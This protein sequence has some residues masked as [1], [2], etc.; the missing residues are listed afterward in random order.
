[1]P[2]G[3]A[4]KTE[5]SSSSGRITQRVWTKDDGDDGRMGSSWNFLQVLL[6]SPGGLGPSWG[7]PRA[8]WG[9]P[10]D[11]PP[12]R[13]PASSEVQAVRFLTRRF[14]G[15]GPCKKCPWTG[16]RVPFEDVCL[17]RQPTIPERAAG[18]PKATRVSG[19]I[20]NWGPCCGLLVAS[21]GTSGNADRHQEKKSPQGLR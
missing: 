17:F 19:V 18:N 8:L 14:R 5:G 21:S 15:Q 16:A 4:C 1:M 12:K 7:L 10:G 3:R 6:G 11:T 20:F 2:I 13:P 9:H